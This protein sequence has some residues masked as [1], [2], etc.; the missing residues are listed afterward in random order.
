AGLLL[1]AAW[2]W[3]ASS[4]E[5][6]TGVKPLN[7]NGT[8]GRALIVYHPGLSDFPDRVTASF[9]AGLA[10]SGWR[11]ERTT[12]SIQAPG[13]LDGYDLLVLG[14]PVYANAAATPLSRY[15]ER[16]GDLRG[17]PVALVFTAAGDAGPALAAT[18]ERATAAHGRVVGKY[19]YTTQRPN[20]ASPSAGGSNVDQAIAMAH[21]A[22]RALSPAAQ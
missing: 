7:S 4:R 11:V 14:S 16:L 2:V 5:V 19:G 12:A 6:V 22:G 8:T 1:A 13:D 9:A 18:A 3:W 15:L 20:G 10:A 21:D 17:K